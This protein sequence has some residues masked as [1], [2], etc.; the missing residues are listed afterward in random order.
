[1]QKILPSS[2]SAFNFPGITS[3]G[4]KKIGY[5]ETELHSHENY[6]SDVTHEAE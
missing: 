3:P 1:M 2:H 4:N 6:M 5:Y